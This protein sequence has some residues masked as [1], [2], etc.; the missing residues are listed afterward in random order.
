MLLQLPR[1]L[2]ASDLALLFGGGNS[3]P[4]WPISIF[5]ILTLVDPCEAILGVTGLYESTFAQGIVTLGNVC[6]I[7]VVIAGKYLGFRCL[8]MNIV[9]IFPIRS[10]WDAYWAATIFFSFVGFDLVAST[11][12]EM[13]NAQIAGNSCCT[14]V[15]CALYIL[16]PIDVVGM[17]PNLC[18]GP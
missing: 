12:E 15:C 7:F 5:L 17:V 9:R 14:S 13:K 8:D 18:D 2:F 4:F 16:V 6:V 1:Y 3:L 10:R 11:A